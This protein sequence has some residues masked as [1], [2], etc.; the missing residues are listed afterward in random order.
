MPFQGSG[1]VV[2]G[3]AQGIGK[4]TAELLAE[5]GAS[6]VLADVNDEAGEAVAQ[7]IRGS[8]AMATYLHCDV[9][10][11][12]QVIELVR[13]ASELLGGLDMAVNN[14]GIAHSPQDLHE[15]DLPT[16]NAVL[17]VTLTGT[18]LCMRE[19]LK[20]MVAQGRGAIVNMASNAGVKNAPDMAGYT[21]AKHGVVG[22]TKNAALQYA[23]RGVR[24]NAV[25]PGTIA[26]EAIASYPAALQHE[27]S[28]MIP[29]GRIGTP[30]EVAQCVAYLLSEQA[31]FIT[32]VPLLI[33]G[34]L[35]FD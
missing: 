28:E 10:V 1:V 8:G 11:E 15:L 18:Y 12:D 4:A 25:C 24:I 7:A 33:D 6:V 27:W 22:L 13:R 21:A 16:W 17:N 26:T 23:R 31:A 3:A 35:M 30:R 19:E 5:E 29:M 34:G 32:G 2:T 9:T 14:A 20:V